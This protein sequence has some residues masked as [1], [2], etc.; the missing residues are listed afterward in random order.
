MDIK[1]SKKREIVAVA[2]AAVMAV[3]AVAAFCLAVFASAI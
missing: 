2:C 3:F 1:T